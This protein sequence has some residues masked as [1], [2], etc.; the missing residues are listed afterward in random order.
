MDHIGGEFATVKAMCKAWGVPQTTYANRVTTGW[1][2]ATALTGKSEVV[3]CPNGLQ[4][5][6]VKAVAKHYGIPYGTVHYRLNSGWSL[7]ESV[8]VEGRGLEVRVL[9]GEVI[10][11]AL[12]V[13]VNNHYTGRSGIKRFP[14]IGII[15]GKQLF[16]TADQIVKYRGEPNEQDSD[17]SFGGTT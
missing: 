5:Q 11:T 15:T 7:A 10:N 6:N 9:A 4:F 13:D 17:R 3:V 8:G 2:L 14:A 12:T 1:D 16:L